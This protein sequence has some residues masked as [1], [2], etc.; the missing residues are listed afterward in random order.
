MSV[1]EATYTKLQEVGW[2]QGKVPILGIHY[3]IVISGLVSG[4]F[5]GIS[6]T[7]FQLAKVRG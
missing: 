2:L 6:D 3:S 7:P 4:F 1:F 5:R